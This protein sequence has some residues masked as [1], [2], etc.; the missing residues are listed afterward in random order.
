M[1]GVGIALAVPELDRFGGAPDPS[2]GM[3]DAVEGE[4]CWFS[5]AGPTLTGIY[6]PE[7]MAPGGAIVGAMSAQAVPPVDSSIFTN[8]G[9][10]AK[11]GGAVD[12]ACQRVDALHGVSF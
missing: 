6:K 3:R 12:P 4:P 8:A 9:C 10:P 7:I 2:G 5:S 1:N 11:G